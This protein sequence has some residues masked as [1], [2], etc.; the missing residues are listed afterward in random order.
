MSFA[1]L[2]RGEGGGFRRGNNAGISPLNNNNNHSGGSAAWNRRGAPDNVSQHAY[3]NRVQQISQQVFRISSNVSTIDRL[4]GFLGTSKDTA[5]VRQKLHTVTEE[6]RELV[7]DV[8]QDIKDLARYDTSGRKLEHQKLSKD[9]QRVL[10]DFQKAQRQSAEKQREFVDRAR[11]ANVRNDYYE[12]DDAD[13]EEQPLIEGAQRR[14]QLQ[15]V[16][17]ELEYNESMIAQRE[18][19]IREIEQGIAELNEVFRD[20]GTMI[21][22]QGSMLDSIES[23]VMSASMATQTAAEELVKAS[24]HQKSARKKSCYLMIIVTFVTLIVVLALLAH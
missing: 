24:E 21:H 19:E 6:T 17:N 9:F 7:K 10:A 11:H 16:D 13:L 4:V 12:E 3:K 23:N 14:M 22:E 18:E 8:G 5:E 20:L 15:V 1:D 2:E